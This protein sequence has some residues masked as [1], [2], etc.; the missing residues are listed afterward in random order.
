M[1]WDLP[2]KAFLDCRFLESRDADDATDPLHPWLR[3]EG[4]EYGEPVTSGLRENKNLKRG[5]P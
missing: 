1:E 2:K 3:A 5:F 4:K